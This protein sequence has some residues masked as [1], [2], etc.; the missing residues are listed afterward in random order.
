M[1]A[2]RLSRQRMARPL[3]GQTAHK[4]SG[5]IALSGPGRSSTALHLDTCAFW[6]WESAH[7]PRPIGS[8]EK[9][10]QRP[11]NLLFSP[12]NSVTRSLLDR[13][14]VIFLSAGELPRASSTGERHRGNLLA[15]TSR[16]LAQTERSLADESSGP[17]AQLI[18]LPV[19]PGQS[20][21]AD[22]EHGRL[23]YRGR[24]E[25]DTRQRRAAP[26]FSRPRRRAMAR[27]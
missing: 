2:R 10:W 24:Y 20:D 26:C 21:D 7:E 6:T 11:R 4:K 17:N 19:D 27:A 14:A 23:V 12:S 1:G 15:L 3:V 25:I 8:L 22:S 9:H 16:M 18:P 13:D 5:E